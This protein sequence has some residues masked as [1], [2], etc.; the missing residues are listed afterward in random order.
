MEAVY[1]LSLRAIGQTMNAQVRR[2]WLTK[3]PES[4]YVV[5]HGDKVVAFFH[6]LPIKHDKLMEFMHGEIRGWDIKA[7]DI[8]NFDTKNP[9]ECLI[10][11]AS[12]PDVNATTR[13]HYVT[14]LLRGIKRKLKELGERGVILKSFYATSQTPT[15]IAMAMHAGMENSGIKASKIQKFVMHTE[16]SKSF[17]LDDY[18]TAI[19]ST[20]HQTTDLPNKR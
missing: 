10:I 7:D 15:G 14:V 13:K 19:K 3:N 5:K 2:D 17:L 12:E 11:I 20:N 18:K 6:L 9:L 16:N 1:E 8:E 4:C